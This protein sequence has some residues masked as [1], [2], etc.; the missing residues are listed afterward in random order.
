[1]RRWLFAWLLWGTLGASEW[2]VALPGWEYRWPQDLRAHPE[3]QT[4]WWYFVGNLASQ[5][6]QEFGYQLTFFRQGVIP[7]S[8]RRQYSSR[9]VPGE[10]IFAHFAVSDL[11]RGKHEAFQHASRGAFDDAGFDDGERLAWIGEWEV[12]H[13]ANGEFRLR[14]T[15]GEVAIDL[16]L[17]PL[18]PA[19]THGEGGVSQKAEGAGR[20]SHYHSLTRIR[21]AGVIRI[22]GENHSVSGLSWFDQ[23]WASNQLAKHQVGWDWFSIQFGNG[24]EL[25]L[26]QMRTDQGGRD[27]FSS[28]TF[29]AADG[30]TRH[31]TAADYVL[32]PLEW[33][34]SPETNG[35]YPVKW[36]IEIPTLDLRLEATARNRSQEMNFQPIAYWEGPVAIEG[37]R[38]R[39]PIEG[40]GYLEMTGY[41]A[42]LEQIRD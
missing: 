8:E 13:L 4:E 5:D 30:T 22:G 34:Q 38:G 28:G 24:T 42:P 23:E 14:A 9:F 17:T 19:I 10:F 1:M 32:T 31:L 18:K 40:R 20:A 7:P 25:M 11:T 37:T 36:S 16:Q 2:Q 6:G 12:R 3:F 15:E 39:S 35:R 27:P 29:V 33:W 41:A 26:Y 21:T